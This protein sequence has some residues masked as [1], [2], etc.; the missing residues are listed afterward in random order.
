MLVGGNWNES[1]G[2]S[3]LFDE[4]KSTANRMEFTCTLDCSNIEY[5][6]AKRGASEGGSKVYAYAM[7]P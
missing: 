7:G 4:D 2:C 6:L 5:W 3:A 1:L